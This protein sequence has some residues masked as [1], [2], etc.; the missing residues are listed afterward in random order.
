MTGPAADVLVAGAGLS[1]LTAAADLVAAGRR[2]LVVEPRT[3]V[4]GRT[5]TIDGNGG[6]RFDLGA[7]WH[8]EGQGEVAALAAR[9]HVEAFPQP[10]GG[11][12]LHEP[13]DGAPPEEVVIAPGPEAR[14]FA[15]GTQQLC[16]R[17]AA[18]LPEGSVRLGWRVNALTLAA[19]GVEATLNDA[20]GETAMVAAGAVVVAVPPRLV[21]QDVWFTPALLP[22]V[23]GVL[24]ATPTWMAEALKCVAVYDS[25]FWRDAGHSGTVFS[26]TGPLAEI[27]DASEP[28]GPAA[29]WGFVALDYDWRTLTPAERT[30]AV[31]EQLARLFG[32]AAADP[33][34]YLE[35]DWS[36]DPNTCEDQHRHVE[37]AAYGHPTLAE[38]LWD[39]RLVWAGTE[40]AA[41]GGGHLE[42]AVVAGRRAARL[43]LSST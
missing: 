27:H 28:G 5:W 32:P 38:P 43:L 13:G 37:V 6:G 33:V 9:L 10:A 1:G 16:E 8:W 31:L 39:G 29:L 42:G 41:D 3:R 36:A 30:P 21:L 34:Q 15:G 25:P 19:D 24:E 17:L 12:V 35:R 18:G 20:A 26:D 7:T 11:S 14:R 4:G 2:V 23:A 40:T 22:E